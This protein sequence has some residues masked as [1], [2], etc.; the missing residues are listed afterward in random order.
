MNVLVSTASLSEFESALP[1]IRSIIAAGETYTLPQDMRDK[2]IRDYFFRDGNQVFKATIGNDIVGVYY[3]RPNQ[4]GGG[5]HV[6]NAGFMVSETARGKGVARTM[7]V[8]ALKTAKGA[9]FEAM[10]FN[11]VVSANT[12]AVKLWQNLGFNI[13]GVIPKGFEHPREGKVD[14]FIMHRFL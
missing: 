8:H 2:E 3:L 1:F 14:A 7:A 6:A 4:S 13:L 12:V 11:F 10:Q 9:G 5:K